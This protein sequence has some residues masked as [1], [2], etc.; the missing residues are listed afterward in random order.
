MAMHG[1]KL[2]VRTRENPNVCAQL[3]VRLVAVHVHTDVSTSA[4]SVRPVSGSQQHRHGTLRSFQYDAL[5]CRVS[6]VATR[7]MGGGGGSGH[8]TKAEC[9]ESVQGKYCVVCVTF[10]SLTQ[11]CPFVAPPTELELHLRQQRPNPLLDGV[12]ARDGELL[13]GAS[14]RCQRVRNLVLL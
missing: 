1:G 11:P 5:G 2:H 6:T 4:P 12:R 7:R 13:D 14:D 10:I 3:G 9:Q 8:L